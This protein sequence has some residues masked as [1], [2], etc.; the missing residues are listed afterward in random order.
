MPDRI[1]NSQISRGLLRNLHAANSRLADIQSQVSSG[2]SINRP[3]D[4]PLKVARSLAMMTRRDD[5]SQYESNLNQAVAWTEGSETAMAS[6]SELV[7]RARTLIVQGANSA[8]GQAERDK[9]VGELTGIIDAVKTQANTKLG[10]EYLFAGSDTLTIPYALGASDVY[11]GNTGQVIRQAAPAV[12]MAV[13]EVGSGVFGNDT[14]GLLKTLRDAVAHLS[15]GTPADIELL[16][17]TDLN[18]LDID[19]STVVTARARMGEL[20]ERFEFNLDRLGELQDANAELLSF[21]RD[22][23]YGAAIIEYQTRQAALEAALKTGQGVVSQ[24]LVDFLR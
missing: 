5:L 21:T 23:D 20:Q 18:N 6:V 14:S 1:T 2:Q 10:E 15:A 7:T 16:R 17:T 13:N 22:T 19:A 12:T 4:D 11:A 24:S 8:N 9:I 3:S